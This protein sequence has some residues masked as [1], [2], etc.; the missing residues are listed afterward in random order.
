MSLFPGSPTNGQIVVVNNI[1]YTYNSSQ[2]AWIRTSIPI[3]ALIQ[4]P[5]GIQGLQG[6]QGLQGPQSPV[7][8]YIFEGGSPSSTYSVGPAFDCG[9]VT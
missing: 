6:V 5:Q 9:G 8:P 1:T 7:I 4:G 2:T 3:P